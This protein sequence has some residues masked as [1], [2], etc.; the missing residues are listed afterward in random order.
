MVS[1]VDLSDDTVFVNVIK[2]TVTL[3]MTQKQVAKALHVTPETVQRWSKSGILPGKSF[4]R[5]AYVGSLCKV[6]LN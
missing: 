4:L 5:T 2:A 3:G 6:I 1:D